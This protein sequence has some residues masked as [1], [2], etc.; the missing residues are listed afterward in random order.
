MLLYLLIARFFV[1]N[2]KLSAPFTLQLRHITKMN[3]PIILTAF[4]TTSR[5]I[6][7][8]TQV[9]KKVSSQFPNHPLYTSFSSRR[10]SAISGKSV[11]RP[12]EILSQ[13]REEGAEKAIIQS[14]HL[15]PGQDFHNL[16]I[17]IKSSPIPVTIG[18][19]LLHDEDD[20]KKTVSA[21]SHNLPKDPSTAILLLG[22]GTSHPSW[23][24]YLA[25]EQ[26]LQNKWGQQRT[27]LGVVEKSPNSDHIAQEIVNKGFT[28]VLVIPFFLILGMH[29][30]RDIVG[31]S[32]D[33]WQSKLTEAGL[34]TEIVENG[35]GSNEGIQQIF[36][37][38]I[39]TALLTTN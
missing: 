15:L 2:T 7:T 24:S 34:D 19:P 17:D 10:I 12:L 35:L 8:Y 29:F 32:P 38:H 11:K 9:E 39:K 27:F 6:D 5:A 20:F 22:H 30:S 31:T 18:K 28:N 3:T 16:V 4:G 14:L 21:L 13:L 23:T 33:S 26:H 37:N 25:L 36:C 1:H